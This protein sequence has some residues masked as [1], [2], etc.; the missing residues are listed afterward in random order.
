MPG[1]A[2]DASP[3]LAAPRGI[4]GRPSLRL[5]PKFTVSASAGDPARSSFGSPLFCKNAAVHSILAPF[6]A[7]M[8]HYGADGF[9]IVQADLDGHLAD[10]EKYKVDGISNEA[11]DYFKSALWSKMREPL[12]DWW[13]PLEKAIPSPEDMNANRM[14]Q[15]CHKLL[16]EWKKKTK[17][18]YLEACKAIKLPE[19]YRHGFSIIPE[20]NYIYAPPSHVEK[21]GTV[22]IVLSSG[23]NKAWDKHGNFDLK[24]GEKIYTMKF[25]LSAVDTYNVTDPDKVCPYSFCFVEADAFQGCALTNSKPWSTPK[26]GSQCEYF[27]KVVVKLQI[28]VTRPVVLCLH[29]QPSRKLF[30]P[31]PLTVRGTQALVSFAPLAFRL[32]YAARQNAVLRRSSFPS[33]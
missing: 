14:Q 1:Q 20:T 10:L 27:A 6:T 23:F 26:P 29:S 15:H 22:M 5:R 16:G 24:L 11:R 8:P 18:L 13:Q 21:K 2:A 25:L 30:C 32:F 7:I 17:E 4:V 28:A 12:F 33:L 19:E 3:S 31:V 9:E